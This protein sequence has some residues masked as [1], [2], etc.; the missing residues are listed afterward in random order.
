MRSLPSA[1]AAAQ[2]PWRSKHP[3]FNQLVSA[4]CF[5]FPLEKESVR[6]VE[7]GNGGARPRGRA[8]GTME[9]AGHRERAD[10]R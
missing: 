4:F 1:F 2:P 7:K 9:P 10:A 3:F 8:Y 5:D 6:G